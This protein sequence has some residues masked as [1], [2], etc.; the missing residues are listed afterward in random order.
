MRKWQQ[1]KSIYERYK[2]RYKLNYRVLSEKFLLL[3]KLCQQFLLK[4]ITYG[5]KRE[6]YQ[7]IQGMDIN[8]ETVK[9]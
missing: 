1:R 5:A 6:D 2:D 7:E 3:C 9:C 4:K 8:L